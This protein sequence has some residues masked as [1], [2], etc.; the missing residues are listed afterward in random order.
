MPTLVDT[1]DALLFIPLLLEIKA[2]IQVTVE[3]FAVVLRQ[4]SENI[5]ANLMKN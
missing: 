2:E 1:T 3:Y 5:Q 4:Q